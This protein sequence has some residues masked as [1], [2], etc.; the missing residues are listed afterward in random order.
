M[1][2]KLCISHLVFQCYCGAPHTLF[3][4]FLTLQPDWHANVL[5]EQSL[6]TPS[7]M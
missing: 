6:P 3:C 2:K 7:P 1:H 4:V 5:Q